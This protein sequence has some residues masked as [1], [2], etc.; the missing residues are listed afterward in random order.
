MAGLIGP[1]LGWDEERIEAEA[2]GYA[3]KRRHELDRAGLDP[4]PGPGRAGTVSGG[5]GSARAG[6]SRVTRPTPVTAIDAAPARVV[7]HL[8]GGPG[9]GGRCPARAAG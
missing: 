7:D 1:E 8:G 4:G 2:T 6:E 9:G 5:P 3:E